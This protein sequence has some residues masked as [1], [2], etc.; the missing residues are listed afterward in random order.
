V[1]LNTLETET[2]QDLWLPLTGRTDDEIMIGD[3]NIV[4]TKGPL[5]EVFIYFP[6]FIY[7]RYIVFIMYFF[8]TIV[9]CFYISLFL[10]LYL[11]YYI[12]FT[13]YFDSQYF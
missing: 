13:F 1:D 9:R 6:L 5:S 10:S 12:L 2:P 8:L 4:V 11:F 3:V 7:F